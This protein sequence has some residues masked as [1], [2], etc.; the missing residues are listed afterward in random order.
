MGGVTGSMS[1]AGGAPRPDPARVAAIRYII[2]DEPETCAAF[3]ES[4]RASLASLNERAL[5]EARS[6]DLGECSAMLD[7]IRDRVAGLNPARLEP[8]AGLAGL[9]DSRSKCLKAFRAAYD[10][11]ASAVSQS[12]ADIGDRAGA[13]ARK[14]AAL[15]TLWSETR[16]AITELDAHIAAARDWLANEGA[17]P[18][19]AEPEPSMAEAAT[20]SVEEAIEPIPASEKA[21]S[22]AAFASEP[23]LSTTAVPETASASVAET[24]AEAPEPVG[25]PQIDTEATAAPA[26]QPEP[27]Q[28]A[29]SEPE[30]AH[31]V[32]PVAHLPHPLETRL[33]ELDA[34]RAVAISRLPLLRAA[35]NADLR[36]PATLKQ[37]CDGVEAWRADWHDALGLAGR[38]PK[39]VRPD[40]I[41]LT[42]ATST[43]TDRIDAA[44]RELSATQGRR[45][46]LKARANPPQAPGRM[47]A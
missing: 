22:D 6:G 2:V 18:V 44:S 19:L 15:E 5:A 26:S 42:G 38:K 43:L 17:T 9:F 31:D 30:A 33:A 37:V 41:R 47:P 28:V 8:R 1:L 35:Q 21:P 24:A 32:A 23:N 12:V 25:H 46:E 27:E 39:K 20:S 29:A 36:A 16:D 40:Q 14:G 34:V 4:V 10:S 13:L 45:A 7:H 11:T 3:G